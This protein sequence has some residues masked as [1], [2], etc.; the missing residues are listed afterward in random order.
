MKIGVIADT[1]ISKPDSNWLG[2][3]ETTFQDVDMLIHAG[4]F[5]CYETFEFLRN[6]KRLYSVWGNCD[7]AKIQRTLKEK[8][9]ITAMGYR[10]GLVHGHGRDKTTLDRAYDQFVSDNVDI[11]IFG[12]SHQPMVQSKRGVLMLNPGSMTNRRSEKWCSYIILE[13]FPKQ[14]QVG[15]NYFS[16]DRWS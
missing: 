13:L 3:I 2:Y 10:I 11:I 7:D 5:V 15:V 6:F 14:F 12:H 1:H 16:T 4:D 8:D 9:I